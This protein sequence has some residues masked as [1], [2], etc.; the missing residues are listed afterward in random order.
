[1]HKYRSSVIRKY[2][3]EIKNEDIRGIQFSKVK[4]K[5][6]TTFSYIKGDIF[7][8]ILDILIF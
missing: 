1:M 3:K 4:K 8:R 5:F 2:I 7:N 6:R